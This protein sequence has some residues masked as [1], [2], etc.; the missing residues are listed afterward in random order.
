MAEPVGKTAKC[1]D[2]DESLA[3]AQLL[4]HFIS[5]AIRTIQLDL[6]VGLFWVHIIPRSPNYLC[7]GERYKIASL[8]EQLTIQQAF[9]LAVRHHQAGRLQEAEQLYRQIVAERPGHWGAMHY[10]GLIAHHN[11]RND[12]AVDLIRRAIALRPDFAEAH[13][14]LGIVL[15]DNGQIDEAIASFGEAIA[16][17]PNYAEAEHN[18]GSAL[19]DNGQLDEAVA[20]YRRAIALSPN[21][22]DAHSNLSNVLRDQGKFDE[23]IVACRQAIALNPNLPEAQNN[24]GSVLKDKGQLD[25]ALA[26]YRQ[27]IALRSDYAEAHSNLGNTLREKGQLEE[28]LAAC[29]YAIT[30]NPKLPE[31]Y[32]N[33]GS[34]LKD[35]GQIAEAVAAYRKAIALSI[36]YA[37]A[38]N[39]LGN[40]LKDKEQFDEGWPS[41]GRPS[42]SGP[43]MLKRTVISAMRLKDKGELDEAIAAYHQAISVN[44]NFAE[45]HN[46]IGNALKDKGQL[47]EALAEY[48]Q[49]IALKPNYV[50]A[51]SNLAFAMHYHPAYDD[52]AIAEEH[53]RWYRQHGEA[54]WK[55][56][57]A[58]SN[59]RSVNRRLRIGYVSP[60]F[61]DHPVGRFVLP[62]LEHHDKSQV[63]VFAY[64]QVQSPDAM[65]GRLRSCTDVW[66]SI[67]GLSDAQAV[68]L[69]RQDQIDI[70]VDLTM[71]SA[72]NRLLIFARKPAPVQV[73]YLAYCSGTGL[74]TIDYRLSDPYLDPPGEES[75]YSEQTVRLPDTYWCYQP[76]VDSPEVGPLPALANGAVTFGCLNNFCK[77]SE[78]TLGAWAKILR[79][80]PDSQLLLSRAG[81]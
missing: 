73:S 36:S 68:E 42:P 4:F 12:A 21:L 32:N 79:E 35:K 46:N 9:E 27:A 20:A 40:A 45:A 29:R 38:H 69:I 72:G 58:H 70:L 6:A 55:F 53:R 14:N 49:A 44:P 74:E 43:T 3:G 67:F 10:L 59:D 60:D 41:I 62:L 57:S 7:V 52:K 65:T 18:L 71:H 33:L 15:K 75:F 23:A 34:V 1:V 63:E 80:V 76:I 16:L 5:P 2:G 54:L 61:R 31:A 64:A 11:G 30:L 24:L 78:K 25:E 28:A 19:R 81:G 13:Y 17:K 66:R 37:E 51:H 22:P 56:I 50:D 77:V 39:N 8:M 48:R 47:D 26:A